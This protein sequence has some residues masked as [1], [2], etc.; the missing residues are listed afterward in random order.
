M[1][2]FDNSSIWNNLF[3]SKLYFFLQLSLFEFPVANIIVIIFV[4]RSIFVVARIAADYCGNSLEQIFRM[5]K[6]WAN[7][8]KNDEDCLEL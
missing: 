4:T 3:Y 1:V 8:H 5:L 7:L 2:L 6:F